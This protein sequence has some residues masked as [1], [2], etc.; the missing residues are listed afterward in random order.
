MFPVRT[1]ESAS[2][3]PSSSLDS[4]AASAFAS[5]SQLALVDAPFLRTSA[6]AH[7]LSHVA[8][9]LD[10]SLTAMKEA[11]SALKALPNLR[12]LRLHNVTLVTKLLQAKPEAEVREL[13][14]E[15]WPNN[16]RALSFHSPC[17]SL[18]GS[19]LLASLP[20]AMPLLKQLT[21]HFESAH[22]AVDVDLQP[23]LQLAHLRRLSL[24]HALSSTQ[25]D[26]VKQMVG[27]RSLSFASSGQWERLTTVQLLLGSPHQLQQLERIDL[28]NVALDTPQVTALA[29]VPTLVAL[30]PMSFVPQC[31]PL[32]ARFPHL[33][34]LRL[35]SSVLAT[36]EQM[37]ALPAILLQCTHLTALSTRFSAMAFNIDEW[38]PLLLQGVPNLRR[39]CIEMAFIRP[40][41]PLLPEHAPGLEE[42]QFRACFG[43]SNADLLAFAH[44]RLKHLALVYCGI[45][46]D[47]QQQ[48]MLHSA[49]LPMLEKI[50]VGP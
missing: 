35:F 33:Q 19:L 12:S 20:V 38:W 40:I 8:L 41:L 30:E 42:L 3:A 2:S 27:L 45:P 36:K 49:A 13:L 7:H 21:L 17:S 37:H 25:C 50:D 16:L 15:T 1:N 29:S 44:P 23:L 24:H 47:P 48:E 31:W 43:I 10:G 34:S 18:E 11:L 26:V 28:A 14:V 46:K 5:S 4:S 6:L 32:L 39:L 22:A 9:Q